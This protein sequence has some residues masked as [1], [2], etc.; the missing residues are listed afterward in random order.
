MSLSLLVL[1]VLAA[2]PGEDRVTVTPTLDLTGPF[3]SRVENTP[4]L[5]GERPRPRIE[6]N[7]EGEVTRLFLDEMELSRGDY[8]AVAQLSSLRFLSLRGTSTTS[9]ALAALREAP[10]L[11]YLVLTETEIDDDALP[12]LV[13]LPRLKTMCLLKVGV[14]AEMV[15]AFKAQR[16]KVSLGY[17]PRP[18]G[19]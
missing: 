4:L 8:Q 16:P 15:R 11:E 7:T 1:V 13:A 18:L 2:P 9:E 19:P 17:S 6:R 3:L 12:H 14:S 10:S 5:I